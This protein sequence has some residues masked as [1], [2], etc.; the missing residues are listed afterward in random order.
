MRRRRSSWASF[1]GAATAFVSEPANWIN[2]G[3]QATQG[4][5][6]EQELI[7]WQEKL[8]GSCQ[9][10]VP[11]YTATPANTTASE[12]VGF[13]LL[14]AAGLT[15]MWALNKSASYLLS[16]STAA[17]KTPAKLPRKKRRRARARRGHARH[18]H[19]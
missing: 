18:A 3:S 12:V 5:A 13:A 4:Q 1:Y 2:T 7:A 11:I 9:L 17:K 10:T 15:S 8:A 6:I 16:H 19:A 14:G